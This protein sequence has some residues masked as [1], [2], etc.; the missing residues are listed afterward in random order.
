MPWYK[1]VICE[2][3]RSEIPKVVDICIF[4]D[5]YD[6]PLKRNQREAA[7]KKHVKPYR[8]TI[9]GTIRQVKKI[10]KNFYDFKMK[11]AVAMFDKAHALLKVLHNTKVKK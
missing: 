10:P 1:V 7:W 4:Y 2:E 11:R 5:W 3:R 6:E 9:K 8:V